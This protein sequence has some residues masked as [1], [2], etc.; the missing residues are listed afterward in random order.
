MQQI[1]RC[2][3]M[4]IPYSCG[5]RA[6]LIAPIGGSAIPVQV[7]STSQ[8]EEISWIRMPGGAVEMVPTT[9]LE[10]VPEPEPVEEEQE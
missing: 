8:N 3:T 6:I 10:P 7:L 5:N 2:G 1:I 9:I 4:R